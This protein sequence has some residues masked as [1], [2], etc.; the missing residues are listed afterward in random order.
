MRSQKRDLLQENYIKLSPQEKLEYIKLYIL[1]FTESEMKTAVSQ[2]QISEYY[3]HFKKQ[4][5]DAMNDAEIDIS[6]TQFVSK[7]KN[8]K[9]KY[10][11]ERGLESDL[12]QIAWKID[13]LTHLSLNFE[14]L[15][16]FGIPPH[17]PKTEK[18]KG[19][20]FEQTVGIKPE[21]LK[22]LREGKHRVFVVYVSGSGLNNYGH[23]LL[24]IEGVGFWHIDSP[25]GLSKYVSIPNFNTYRTVENKTILGLQEIQ[26]KS[27]PA[28]VAKLNELCKNKWVWLGVR[29]N[30]LSFCHEAIIAGGYDPAKE[31]EFKDLFWMLPTDWLDRTNQADLLIEREKPA[32]KNSEDLINQALEN[33]ISTFGIVDYYLPDEVIKFLLY[34][35]ENMA[36]LLS[37]QMKLVEQ[38]PLEDEGFDIS[39]GR[40][41]DF[42]A[43]RITK[44]LDNII[45]KIQ[46]PEYLPLYGRTVNQK[47]FKTHIADQIKPEIE[48]AKHLYQTKK[49]HDHRLFAGTKL[50]SPEEEKDKPKQEP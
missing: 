10:F 19:P 9:G 44:T 23:A 4:L 32:P 3:Q 8:W 28:M 47:Y 35:V 41:I 42:V 36:E 24:F 25:Y 26:I 29:H 49:E 5:K 30:C 22:L 16:S 2:Q 34:A 1:E 7:L 48:R 6:L 33:G 43:D 20:F 50:E 40:D 46:S 15:A 38:L 17:L 39:I 31:A 14:T 21:L 13:K 11:L 12:K 27:Y 45:K 18:A 37:R